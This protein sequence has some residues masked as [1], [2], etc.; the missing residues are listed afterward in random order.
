MPLVLVTT[1]ARAQTPK[2]IRCF[3]HPGC[4]NSGLR[5][6]GG[7]FP[8][9]FVCQR[10]P[11]VPLAVCACSGFAIPTI[12]RV[13]F[14]QCQVPFLSGRMVGL[15]LRPTCLSALWPT[16]LKL[17]CIRAR[18]SVR[19]LIS[20]IGSSRLYGHRVFQERQHVDS[21]TS[22][23]SPTS[24]LQGYSSWQLTSR[25]RATKP[26]GSPA[27]NRCTASSLN[28]LVNFLRDLVQFSLSLH[29]RA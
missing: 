6:P 28:S 16:G 29:F 13:L 1:L 20:R 5:R 4:T 18:F 11:R 15:H 26:A 17:P 9:A 21:L 8:K 22:S 14:A 2:A 12:I 23:S 10:A 3:V 24:R 27:R 19:A 7:T 25:L